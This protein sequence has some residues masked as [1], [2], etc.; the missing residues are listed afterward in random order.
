VL[1]PPVFVR[2]AE[3]VVALRCVALRC[4]LGWGLAERGWVD[5]SVRSACGCEST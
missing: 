2:G 3:G 4:V 5:F 1:A